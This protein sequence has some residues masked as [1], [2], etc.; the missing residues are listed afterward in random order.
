MAANQYTI[1]LPDGS[2]VTVQSTLEDRLAFETA[3]RK[4]KHWGKLADNALRLQPFL[5]WNAARREGLLSLS[6]EEFTTGKTAALSVD[7]VEDDEDDELEVDGLGKDTTTAPSVTSPSSS[8]V[9]TAAPRGTGEAT[10][11][12]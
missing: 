2:T 12:P 7:A 11:A 10:P 8:L 4:N 6:W 1:T 5:A 9:T 3:L